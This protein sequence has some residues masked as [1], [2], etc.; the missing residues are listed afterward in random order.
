MAEARLYL[1]SFYRENT[2]TGGAV[3]DKREEWAFSAQDARYQVELS[4]E[5]SFPS[6]RYFRVVKIE[7]V[8]DPVEAHETTK[9]LA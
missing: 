9:W 2:G 8:R 6:D 3:V 1:V 5:G 4:F 7:P